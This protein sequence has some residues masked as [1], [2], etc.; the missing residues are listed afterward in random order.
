MLRSIIGARLT[1]KV[2]LGEIYER[3]QARRVQVVARSLKYKYAG[4]TIRHNA[5]KWNTILSSWIPH[6]HTGE[7]GA[8][9]NL[10]P[11]GQIS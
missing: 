8:G 6:C 4:H 9:G 5:N 7:K 2:P 3:T 10:A 11:D 1:D